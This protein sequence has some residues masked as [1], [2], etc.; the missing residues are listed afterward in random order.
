MYNVV[1]ESILTSPAHDKND[2]RRQKGN[3]QVCE[4]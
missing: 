3:E 1:P 2:D 4:T